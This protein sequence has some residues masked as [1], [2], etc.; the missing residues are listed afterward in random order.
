MNLMS[1]AVIKEN[2]EFPTFLRATVP[3]ESGMEQP[4]QVA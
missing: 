4:R 1:K 2:K 3:M